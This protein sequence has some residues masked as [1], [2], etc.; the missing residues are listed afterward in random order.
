MHSVHICILLFSSSVKADA[1][2]TP[3]IPRSERRHLHRP[4]FRRRSYPVCNPI[5]RSDLYY[6]TKQFTYIC[7]L[8]L[9]VDDV[10]DVP[11]RVPDAHE[12]GGLCHGVAVEAQSFPTSLVRFV[13]VVLTSK[14]GG[15]AEDLRTL[16][17]RNVC[18]AEIT[19]AHT[20]LR[21][22]KACT[23]GVR[24]NFSSS[25]AKLVLRKKTFCGH[26]A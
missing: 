21:R 24:L 8:Y 19:L 9:E 20:V 13:Q 23:L 22:S 26:R 12:P 5:P 4:R 14:D 25:H 1:D 18:L 16:G 11:V 7:E 3:P 2:T 10:V 15:A 6:G 17:A